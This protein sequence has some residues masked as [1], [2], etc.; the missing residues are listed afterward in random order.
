MK[1][2]HQIVGRSTNDLMLD[3]FVIDELEQ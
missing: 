2:L 3:L 1:G